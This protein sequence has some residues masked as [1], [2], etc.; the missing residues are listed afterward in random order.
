VGIFK[1]TKIPELS[2]HE[3]VI[4]KVVKGRR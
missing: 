4:F 2:D 1:D 3:P